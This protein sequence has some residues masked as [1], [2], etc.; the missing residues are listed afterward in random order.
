MLAARGVLPYFDVLSVKEASVSAN[1][2]G[3]GFYGRRELRNFFIDGQRPCLKDLTRE[4]R[5][6]V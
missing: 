5:R 3:W 6:T 1:N 4:Q 2:R